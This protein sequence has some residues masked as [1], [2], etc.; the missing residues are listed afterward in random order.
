[1]SAANLDFALREASK[2]I[3]KAA[4]PYVYT[5]YLYT[6]YLEKTSNPRVEADRRDEMMS[7]IDDIIATLPSSDENVARAYNLR[8][9]LFEDE[10]S[11]EQAIQAYNAAIQLDPDLAVAHLNLGRILLS[12]GKDEKAISYIRRAALLDQSADTFREL[13]AILL[14]SDRY[15]ESA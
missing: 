10:K 8:G 12:E 15:S 4:E 5:S 2:K 9:L 14:N 13:A 1:M 6:L 11:P 3:I 7:N